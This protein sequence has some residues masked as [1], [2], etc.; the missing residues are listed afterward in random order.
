MELIVK[1]LIRHNYSLED[2]QNNCSPDTIKDTNLEWNEKEHQNH[3]YSKDITDNDIVFSVK[4]CGRNEEYAYFFFKKEVKET[5]TIY[6]FEKSVIDTNIPN[7]YLQ[8][9]LNLVIRLLNNGNYLNVD[10]LLY[11]GYNYPLVEY[12]LDD[13]IS[14]I[15]Q[16]ILL[17]FQAEQTGITPLSLSHQEKTENAP[18]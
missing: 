6:S 3:P 11:G 15:S 14:K 17:R 16:N 5:V 12:Q 7:E 1:Q 9:T 8:S 4:W 13:T 10:R 18:E 2:L